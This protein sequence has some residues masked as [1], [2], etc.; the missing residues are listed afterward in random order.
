VARGKVL[1]HDF[2]LLTVDLEETAREAREV[3]PRVWERFRA[4]PMPTR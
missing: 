1:M 4:L 3:A 2:E